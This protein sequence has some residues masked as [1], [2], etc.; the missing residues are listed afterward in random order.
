MIGRPF[1]KTAGAELGD[2]FGHHLQPFRLD[3]IL[4]G[5]DHHALL[6]P[7]QP[8]DLEMFDGLGH[9]PFVGGNDKGQDID[10]GDPGHH[11]LDKFFM[12]RHI[13]DAQAV[14]AGQIQIGK[15]QLDGDAPL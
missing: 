10:A 11:G 6:H 12:A 14:A 9:D 3:Q 4:F 2:L 15:A 7:H 1:E 8:A 5:N 13:D